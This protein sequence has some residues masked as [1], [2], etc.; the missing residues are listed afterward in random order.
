MNILDYK[1]K[2]QLSEYLLF[3]TKLIDDSG[4]QI[5]K[6]V[7]IKGDIIKN[8]FEFTVKINKNKNQGL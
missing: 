8:M 6:I 5:G 4:N 1:N 3:H 7:S 2:L